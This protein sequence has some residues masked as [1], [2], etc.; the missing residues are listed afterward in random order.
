MGA[1]RIEREVKISRSVE[2][3]WE[4]LTDPACVGTWFGTGAPAEIDLRPGGVM[5][6][7]HGEHGMYPTL[8]VEVDPPRVLSYRWASA[9][10]GVV[11]NEAN[12]TLVT[13]TLEPAADGTLLR[14]VESGFDSLVIPLG[15]EDSAGF[16]SHSKGWTGVIAKLGEY[17]EGLDESPLLPAV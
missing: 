16:E 17:A 5:V 14:V 15:R 12:S 9:Y 8:I 6:L 4:V 3:V 13:F 10:P 7:D 2:R 11:A 1:D